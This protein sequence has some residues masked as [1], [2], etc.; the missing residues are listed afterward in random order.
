[1]T[2]VN[3]YSMKNSKAAHVNGN[4][5]RRSLLLRAYF[6]TIPKGISSM[7]LRQ[8]IAIVTA[9]I[10]FSLYASSANAFDCPNQFTAAQAK[11]DMAAKAVESLSGQRKAEV[12]MLLDDAKMWLSSAKH[13]HA[14]PQGK[15]DH[16]RSIAKAISAGGYA[17]AAVTL[18][19][20]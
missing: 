6:L 8:S 7:K 1:M 4:G 10:G 11:I 12:H 3:L 19:G 20:K 16:G 14:K 5:S 13:N 15:M 18:A 9:V 17:D 2:S